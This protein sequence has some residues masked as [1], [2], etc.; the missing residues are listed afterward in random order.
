MFGANRNTFGNTNNQPFGSNAGTSAF[1]NASS[2]NTG[3][4]FGMTQNNVN[5]NTQQAFGGFGSNPTASTNTG[6]SLFGGNVSSQFGQGN[7]ATQNMNPS[8]SL[9]GGANNNNTSSMMMGGNTN[10][11]GI[12]KAFTPYREKDPTTNVTNIFQSISCMPE[13]RNVSFEELRLQ[14]YQANRKFSTTQNIGNTVGQFGQANNT[15]SMAPAFGG[16]NTNTSGQAATGGGLFGQ[17]PAST[18]FGASVSG[19][20]GSTNNTSNSLFGAKPQTMSAGSLFGQQQNNTTSGGLF[21]QQNNSASPFG[22]QQNKPFGAATNAGFGA[23]SNNSTNGLFGQ[24]N[25]PQQGGL[26]GQQTQQQGS[27]AF[28][29]AN[30]SNTTFGGNNQTNNG[31]F[32]QGNAQTSGGLFGAKP[33]GGLFGQQTTNNTLGQQQ[34]SGGL[35]GSKPAT[36]GGLF[37]QNTQQAAQQGGLFGQQNQTGGAFGQQTNNQSLLGQNNQ[38]NA[39]GLFGN[40]PAT[41]GG[42]FGQNNTQPVQQGGLFGQNGNQQQQNQGGLFGQTN[43]QQQGGLFGQN[44]SQQQGGLFGQNNSQPQQTQGG[45]FGQGNGQPQQQSG[46]LFGNKPATS[47]SLFGNNTNSLNAPQQAA[48]G[49][50]FG[51][52]PATSGGLFGTSGGTNGTASTGLFGGNSANTANTLGST[53]TSLFGN[54]PSTATGPGL[55]SSSNSASTGTGGLFGSKPAGQVS[56]GGLFGNNNTGNTNTGLFG[57]NTSQQQQQ[58]QQPLG[59]LQNNTSIQSQNQVVNNPYGTNE[60]FSKVSSNTEMA[61]HRANTTKINADLKK[62]MSL[63]LA[64]KLA[65]KPLFTPAKRSD[66]DKVNEHGGLISEMISQFRDKDSLLLESGSQTPRKILTVYS[67]PEK[68]SFKNLILNKRM[69]ETKQDMI[70]GTQVKQEVDKENTQPKSVSNKAAVNPVDRK[71]SELVQNSQESKP[72]LK[73]KGNLPDGCTNEDFSWVDNNYYIS[74]SLDTLSTYSALQLRKVKNLVVGHKLFGKIEFLDPVD[75]SKIPL[76]SI[77]GK[78]VVFDHKTCMLYPESLEKPLPGNELNVRARI[79][80]FGCFP[81]NKSTRQPIKDPNHELVKRHVARFKNAKH[82]KFEKYD[83]ETG[84]YAFIAPQPVL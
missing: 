69:M 49:G 25:Q 18:G 29:M 54:K 53:G 84:T 11:S 45:L 82:T 62:K 76:A 2:T 46:G 30:N 5:T 14:D 55:F 12:N 57:N 81:V 51:A 19:A 63:S 24:Q 36:G 33:A 15:G 23:N 48:A 77:C 58:Q 32:G 44:N 35:F 70:V 66:S 74:P 34:P 31:L 52:K 27:N 71:Q 3:N 80:C 17:K 16:L 73:T 39:G 42:L 38:S 20:F 72:P 10:V 40:K 79:T 56:G 26:F 67:H 6:S 61:S 9:F 4:G 59:Q 21:G 41:T 75:L 22:Q 68:S 37:G 8:G 64:Y 83:A 1:G 13:Y 65:P 28:G 7:T 60:L 50:L 78:L 47:G 43:T